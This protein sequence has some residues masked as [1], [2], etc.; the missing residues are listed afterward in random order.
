MICPLR[1]GHVLSC[2]SRVHVK[3]M[4]LMVNGATPTKPNKVEKLAA[5]IEGNRNGNRAYLLTHASVNK[6]ENKKSGY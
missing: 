5:A 1:E 3:R 6:P 4:Y 2:H